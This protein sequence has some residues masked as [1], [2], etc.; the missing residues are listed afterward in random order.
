MFVLEN[1]C[2]IWEVSIHTLQAI[3]TCFSE[4]EDIGRDWDR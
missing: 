1:K 4:E 2:R 3:F